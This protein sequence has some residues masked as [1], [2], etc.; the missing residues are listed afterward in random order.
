MCCVQSIGIKTGSVEFLETV[1]NAAVWKWVT[2]NYQNECK[3]VD[4]KKLVVAVPRSVMNSSRLSERMR[5]CFVLLCA[6]YLCFGS[7]GSA[8][9]SG[10]Q[11]TRRV[12]HGRPSDYKCS[13]SFGKM[14]YFGCGLLLGSSCLLTT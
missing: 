14:S 7:R 6:F 11:L 10:A 3:A 2:G 12:P 8:G 1:N 4:E 13:Y 5:R 9:D